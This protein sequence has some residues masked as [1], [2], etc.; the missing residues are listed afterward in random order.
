LKKEE[1]SKPTEEVKAAK[2]EEKKEE[3]I[4]K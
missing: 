4:K 3:E 1:P 2:V